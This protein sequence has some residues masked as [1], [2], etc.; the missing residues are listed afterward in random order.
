MALG[1]QQFGSQTP[2]PALQLSRS[3]HSTL[4]RMK[5]GSE[6]P[7]MERSD[8]YV[9]FK[10]LKQ[11]VS[12]STNLWVLSFCLSSGYMVISSLILFYSG[13]FWLRYVLVLYPANQ[14]TQKL[15]FLLFL[16]NRQRQLPVSRVHSSRHKP[17]ECRYF[18][19]IVSC[20]A[21]DLDEVRLIG[22]LLV[23]KRYFCQKCYLRRKFGGC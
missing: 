4:P 1:V 23:A 19:G 8:G 10:D 20:M 3:L 22:D 9:V 6:S 13:E 12:T 2:F 18:R 15:I 11:K 7:S 14:M 16:I 17:A 21:A 5:P